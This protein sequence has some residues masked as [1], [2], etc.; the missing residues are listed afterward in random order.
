MWF[1]N[2]IQTKQ[3]GWLLTADKSMYLFIHESI[4]A[5][6][7]ALIYSNSSDVLGNVRFYDIISSYQLTEITVYFT[8]SAY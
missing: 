8:M 2:N 6:F 4:K 3:I 1:P 5:M 7:I